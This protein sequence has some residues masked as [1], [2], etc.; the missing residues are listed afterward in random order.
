[1]PQSANRKEPVRI[2]NFLH[3]NLHL[4]GLASTA[5]G[6]S[7]LALTPPS[8]AEVIYTPAHREVNR[9]SVVPID[10]NGDGINDVGVRQTFRTQTGFHQYRLQAVPAHGGG[11]FANEAIC[12]ASALRSGAR[13]GPG[14][15]FCTQPASMIGYSSAY[16]GTYWG[17]WAPVKINRYL[18]VKFLIHGQVHYGWARLDARIY[19]PYEK[20]LLTGFAYETAPNKPIAA[21][22]EGT[23]SSTQRKPEAQIDTLPGEPSKTPPFVTLGAL[24]LGAQ[25]ISTWRQNELPAAK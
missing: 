3:R 22:D 5:A 19:F 13:I 23:G 17:L 9:N 18:G 8:E 15:I 16:D 10:F 24:A 11:I 1:M 2:S 12:D 6:V 25:A 20:A 14:K 4:Y 21:G 7:L